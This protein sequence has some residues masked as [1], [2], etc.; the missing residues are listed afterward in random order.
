LA[1]CGQKILALEQT[2]DEEKKINNDKNHNNTDQEHLG[3][4][5]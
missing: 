3:E 5:T 1:L 4:F 2:A